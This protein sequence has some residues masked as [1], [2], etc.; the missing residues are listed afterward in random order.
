MKRVVIGL[1]EKNSADYDSCIFPGDYYDIP[2]VEQYQDIEKVTYYAWQK[3]RKYKDC[4]VDLYVNGGLSVELLTALCVMEHLNIQNKIFHWDR[5]KN[6]YL[7]QEFL[8]HPVQ[9]IGKPEK[10]IYL[11][12]ERH[13]GMEGES[14]FD[15]ISEEQRFDFKWQEEQAESVLKEFK[16]NSLK[17]YVTGLKSLQISTMNAAYKCNIPITWMHYDYDTER[18]FAQDINRIVRLAVDI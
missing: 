12:R 14:I 5:L 4:K 2:N 3:V 9:K 16:D 15:T 6:K 13:Y 18:Y 8:W 1:T 17:I 11:C 7:P 10:E